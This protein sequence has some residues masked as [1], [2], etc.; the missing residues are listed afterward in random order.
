MSRRRHQ[1]N[2]KESPELNITAF[3]NLMV[4]LIPFLLLSAAFNQLS[5][6]ELYL[7]K[8]GDAIVDTPPD[9]GPQLEI[10]VRP[11]SLTINDNKKGPYLVIDS[12]N[13]TYDYAAM[14]AKLLD[15]KRRLN[16]VT[17]ITLLA[18]PD[19]AY[20]RVVEIM[21]RVRQVRAD[22]GQGAMVNYELFPDIGLG[23]APASNAKASGAAQP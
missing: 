3:L 18:E 13:G 22:N 8:T 23:D 9:Q 12:I 6:L 11:G 17:Q 5:V 2:R 10:I 14:Q 4:V 7:P 16:D 15:M 1:R 20:N 19:I 21:D